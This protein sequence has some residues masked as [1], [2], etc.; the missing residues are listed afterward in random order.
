MQAS[1]L[2]SHAR[3]SPHW[4]ITEVGITQNFDFDSLQDY[5][6]LFAKSGIRFAVTSHASVHGD[7]TMALCRVTSCNGERRGQVGKKAVETAY[8][9]ADSLKFFKE[10]SMSI[11]Y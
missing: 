11:L 9:D 3:K 1:A 7:V 8:S 4:S 5:R 6:I 2:I 10:V